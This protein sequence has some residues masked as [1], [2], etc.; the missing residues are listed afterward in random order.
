MSYVHIL[1]VKDDCLYPMHL[2][3][4]NAISLFEKGFERALPLLHHRFLD[5][6]YVVVDLNKKLIV[7][8]QSAFPVGRYAKDLD[9][10]DA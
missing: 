7:N 2:H 1:V 8:C 9:V 10:F 3:Y 6:G 5:S 4:R